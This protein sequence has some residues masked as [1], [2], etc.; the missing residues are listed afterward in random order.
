MG[1]KDMFIDFLNIVFS[2]LIII[3]AIFVF[4]LW[5]YFDT[6]TE[7]LKNLAPIGIFGL[8][9]IVTLK[10]KTKKYQ[11][12]KG[13]GNLDIS[14]H[15][16]YMDKIKMDLLTFGLPLIIC[17]IPLMAEG[18]VNSTHILQAIIVFIIMALF[19]QHLFNKAE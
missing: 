12:K 14:L 17:L 9:F 15:L 16:T 7:L 5:G 19:T 13:E 3:G 11:K 2:I 1:A 6:F 8:G 10:L 4:A 18:V